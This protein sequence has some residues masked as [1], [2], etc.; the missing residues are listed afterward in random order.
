MNRE[1]EVFAQDGAPHPCCVPSKKRAAQLDESRRASQERYRVI[2][3][4]TEGMCRLDGGVFLMGAD[5][6][7]SFPQDGEGP[8][9]A[10]WLD[11]FYVDIYPVTNLEFAEF[12]RATGYK[13][14]SEQ[15][16]WSF[17]FQGHIPTER[18]SEL[19]TARVPG[20]RWW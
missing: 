15:L 13:T 9:R 16:G 12:V 18:C 14:E 20:A 5:S 11:P 3:G 10:V 17:V 8:V 7:E 2:A 6:S 1:F 19:I 4:S